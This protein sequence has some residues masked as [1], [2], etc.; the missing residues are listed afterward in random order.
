MNKKGPITFFNEVYPESFDSMGISKSNKDLIDSIL[1]TLKL[2][3][4]PTKL[5]LNNIKTLKFKEDKNEENNY[6]LDSN[7]IVHKDNHINRELFLCASSNET[8]GLSYKLKNGKTLGMAL[9]NGVIDMFTS[10]NDKTYKVKYPFPKMVAETIMYIFGIEIFEYLFSNDPKGFL[11][12]FKNPK[13]IIDLMDKLDKFEYNYERILKSKT[14]KDKTNI[15]FYFGECLN[16]L[17]SIYHTEKGNRN[18]ISFQRFIK[19]GLTEKCM[20]DVMTSVTYDIE[21]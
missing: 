15:K 7:K 8:T 13:L 2:Y 17:A 16:D 6:L 9:T 18:K 3:N 21:E 4:M 1:N 14:K 11:A 19:N 12:V 5:F 20:L 10:L